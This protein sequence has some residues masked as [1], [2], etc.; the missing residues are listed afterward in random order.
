MSGSLSLLPQERGEFAS[1]DYWDDFFRKRGAKAFEWYG[2]Y[3]QLCGLLHKYIKPKDTILNIG[4]G[5]SKL[6]ADVYDRGVENITNVDI[7]EIVIKQMKESNKFRPNMKWEVG[8]VTDLN[9]YSDDNFSVV[10]DKGTLDALF[11]DTEESTVQ[12]VEKMFSEISRLLKFGGRYICLTLAQDFI[13]SKQLNWFME[14]EG[15]IIR[16]H[17]VFDMEKES[18][19]SSDPVHHMPLFAVVCAKLKSGGATATNS[20]TILEVGVTSEEL[21]RIASLDVALNAIRSVQVFAVVRNRISTKEHA[22]EELPVALYNSENRDSPRY[23]IYVI[24]VQESKIAIKRSFAV[25]IV[26]EG[27]ETEWLFSTKE[28]RQQLAPSAGFSRLLV[29]LLN[30]EHDYQDLER[31]KAELSGKVLELAPKERSNKEVP[32]LSVGEDIG[33]RTVLERG[34]SAMS[35]DFVVEDVEVMH[36]A[37]FRRL[38][39]LNNPNVIQSESRML[40]ETT[41]KK[42]KKRT[43]TK[44]DQSYLAFEHNRV[45]VAALALL[46]DFETLLHHRLKTLLIGVGG[47]NMAT[48]LHRHLPKLEMEAVEID[49]ALVKVAKKHF[50][51]N[52]DARLKT[53]VADGLQYLENHPIDSDDDKFHVIILDCDNKDLAIGISYPPPAFLAPTLL[54]RISSLLL[55]GGV[56]VLNLVCRDSS[57]RSDLL[58]K[59]SSVFG[60]RIWSQKVKEQVNE[61][62]VCH[63]DAN[64]EDGKSEEA[65]VPDYYWKNAKILK[66]LTPSIYE[67]D[68]ELIE[69]FKGLTL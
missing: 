59:L 25:F 67:S 52:T 20:S 23:V 64:N 39:F 37:I 46:R 31:V 21:E 9:N 51:L 41:K 3:P 24:D 34:H 8:D 35:G 27:R 61:I 29:V 45:V 26:P 69:G 13:I 2:E 18:S 33:K 32:F 17:R 38:I 55:P 30:R 14:D 68:D 66:T 28:G 11:A 16:V 19:D 65:A 63:N 57:L 60:Q 62:V 36:A 47:G 10:L 50:G 43:T 44:L 15:W 54:R 58:Q 53:H 12:T 49:E 7:S 42:G 4:C 22:G 5:N 1:K 6:S 40:T 48:F 56:F